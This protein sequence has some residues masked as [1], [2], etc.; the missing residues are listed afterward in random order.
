VKLD[1]WSMAWACLGNGLFQQLSGT[2]TVRF[3]IRC[4]ILNG[5]WQAAASTGE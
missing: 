4:G 1:R 5:I 3:G 2:A